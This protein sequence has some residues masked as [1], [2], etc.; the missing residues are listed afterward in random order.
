MGTQYDLIIGVDAGTSVIK[1]VAFDLSGRQLATASVRNAYDTGA[2]GS[3]TQSLPRTWADC[4][5]ALRGLSDKIENLAARAA[6]VALTGQGDGTWL[7][8]A[9]NEAVTDAWLW[10]DARAAPTVP[11]LT[12]GAGERARFEATGTGLR[13]LPEDVISALRTEMGPVYEELAANDPQFKKVMDNYFAFKAEHDIWA[14]ASEQ[15][16]HSQLR[17]SS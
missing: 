3:A 13:V 1:A 9:G 10:L 4:A 15:V 12:A 16:W 8:G 7:V 6:A 11:R 5:A 2:D 14:G 17:S